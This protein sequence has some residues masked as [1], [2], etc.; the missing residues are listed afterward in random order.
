MS[1]R[2]SYE[3]KEKIL[4][5]VK[6]KPLSYAE[7]ERKVNT[8]YRTIKSNCKELEHFGQIKIETIKHPANGRI[9]HIVSITKQ[10]IKLLNK[11]KAKEK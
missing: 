6:E 5:C 3:I 11:T 8:G 10:G 7:L 2:S 9:A 1:K 4:F